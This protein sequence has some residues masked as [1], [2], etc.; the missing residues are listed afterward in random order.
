[1]GS[2]GAEAQGSP[3][4]AGRGLAIQVMRA[5]LYCRPEKW[6]SLLGLDPVC[7]TGLGRITHSITYPACD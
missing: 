2:Q 5:L 7:V 3:P 1:M 4:A 6:R